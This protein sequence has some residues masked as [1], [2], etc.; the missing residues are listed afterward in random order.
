MV[1]D[2]NR[3]RHWPS[4]C[5]SVSPASLPIQPS[6]TFHGFT[7]Q[8]LTAITVLVSP[9]VFMYGIKHYETLLGFSFFRG[10]GPGLHREPDVPAAG[11]VD[12]S[13]SFPNRSRQ[14]IHD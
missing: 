14:R 1:P 11:A 4:P 6:H 10:P 13:A 5:R 3:W 9:T 2:A 12:Q 7:F 8:V